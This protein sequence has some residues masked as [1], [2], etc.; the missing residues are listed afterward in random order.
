MVLAFLAEA[1]DEFVSGEAISRQA[2]ASR[3]PRSGSTSRRSARRATGSTRSRRAAT[4][5]SAIPD[6]LGALEIRPLL[7]THDLGQ[8][9]HCYEELD[10]TNDRAK[11]L[12]EEGA[13]HGEVVV[14]EPQTARARAARA[15]PG[16]RPPGATSTSRSILRPELPPTRAPELTLVAV[17]GRLRRAAGGR[18]GRRASSGRTTCW[19]AGR[20]IAGILTEL[21]AEPDHVHW[22]VLGIGVNLNAAPGGLPG[23][24]ARRGHQRPHRAGAAGA[25]RALHGGAAS[26]ARGAGSTC[27]P[28][29]GSRRS[30]TPGGSGPSRSG[31]RSA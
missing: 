21:S 29:R 20:K 13:A 5:S 12:A 6:R 15:R 17:A 7:T 22:V 31:A 4:G 24:A 3:A 30:G 28:R 10:S 16:P 27:T 14:A 19:S 1:A 11:E 2:R 9:L 25:A 23:G 26:L 18:G 8:T